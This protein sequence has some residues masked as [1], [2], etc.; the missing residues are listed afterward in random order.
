[1]FVG[2]AYFDE[3]A[4]A[5]SAARLAFNRS[6]KND[7]NMRVF[8]AVACGSLLLTNDLADNGQAESV[9][10]RSPPGDLSATRMT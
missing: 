5:Y 2:R 1:M 10:R 3:M 7:V 9:P 4:R 6:V 8:E